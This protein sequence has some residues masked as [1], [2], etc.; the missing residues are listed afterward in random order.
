MAGNCLWD[1][2]LKVLSLPEVKEQMTPEYVIDMGHEAMKTGLMI[3][4][5]LLLTA[6]FTG[7]VVSVFQAAT[8]INEMTLSFIPKMLMIIVVGV[9]FAPFF[10]E[11]FLDYIRNLYS[12]IPEYIR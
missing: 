4:L 3:A 9:F 11:T 6:L 1:H 5:P 10:L 7:L 12:S 8:Q 2:W